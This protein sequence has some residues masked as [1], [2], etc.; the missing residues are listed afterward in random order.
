VERGSTLFPGPVCWLPGSYVSF[1]DKLDRTGGTDLE[2]FLHY[3]TVHIF[4][5]NFS[6][7]SKEVF[8]ECVKRRCLLD[9][10]EF[11]SLDSSVFFA[12]PISQVQFLQEKCRK[13]TYCDRSQCFSC[14]F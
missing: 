9:S 1:F 11:S 13:Y 5:N 14:V 8:L 12:N 4:P 3:M 6:V 7:H 2:R 10:T